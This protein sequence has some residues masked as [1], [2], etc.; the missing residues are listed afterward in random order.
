M[1]R[2]R[3]G[4]FI[5]G[6][7]LVILG[8]G[9]RRFSN[10]QPKFLAEYSGDTIWAAMV[11]VFIAFL[12]TS[13]SSIRVGL[14]ALS[15]A[16]AIETSQLY[17]TGWI[18]ALRRNRI[19]GLVLGFGFLWSDLLCYTVGVTLCIAVESVIG[20]LRAWRSDRWSSKGE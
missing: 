4:Y 18:D 19:G 16:F 12:R 17:H 8:L 10:L 6:V 13:W 20:K 2:N 11:F 14:V 5:A 9:S 1:N 7:V 3:T 15:F